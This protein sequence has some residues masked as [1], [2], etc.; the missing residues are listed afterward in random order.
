MVI[1]FSS[2]YMNLLQAF[3]NGL[4]QYHSTY[5]SSKVRHHTIL[6]SGKKRCLQTIADVGKIW[7]S[8]QRAITFVFK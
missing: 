2:L 5:L 7:R 8:D 3:Q 6:L 1:A 4:G